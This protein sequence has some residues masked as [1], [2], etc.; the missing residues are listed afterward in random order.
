LDDF[1]T[2]LQRWMLNANFPVSGAGPDALFAATNPL[3]TFITGG[4]YFAAPYDDRFIGA[5]IFD[6]VDSNTGVLQIRLTVVDQN[7]QPDPSASLEGAIFQITDPA[8]DQLPT[9][10]TNAAGHATVPHLPI[11]VELTV[12]QTAAPAGASIKSP[13]SVTVTLDHCKPGIVRFN[14]LRSG[15][16]GGYGS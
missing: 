2:I 6:P 8:G 12:T 3:A 1:L 7:G 10:T 4:L 14:D 15:T 16:P 5:G 9:A 13:A 11:G